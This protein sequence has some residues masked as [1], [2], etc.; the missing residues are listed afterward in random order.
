MSDGFLGCPDSRAWWSTV[1]AA[2]QDLARMERAV[3][4][5]RAREGLRGAPVSGTGRASGPRDA[6]RAT[7]ARMDYEAACAPAMESALALLRTADRLLWGDAG[8]GVAEL[9]GATAASVVRLRHVDAM[10]WSEV[11]RSLSLSP[12]ACR[13]ME[14]AAMDLMDALGPGRVLDGNGCATEPLPLGN[15][16]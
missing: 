15:V 12:S 16:W 13:Q 4:R 8:G 14:G 6:N 3:G 2:S 5:M 10:P 9:L 7:D 1:R 11:A